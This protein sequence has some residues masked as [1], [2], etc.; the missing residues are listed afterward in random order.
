MCLQAM[1][2]QGHRV[3][4][5]HSALT[6]WLPARLWTVTRMT[7]MLNRPMTTQPIEFR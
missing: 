2:R 5:G 4:L 1:L 3:M 6:R 7:S